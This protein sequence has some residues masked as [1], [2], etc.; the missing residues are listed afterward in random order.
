[1]PQTD[2]RTPPPL[3]LPRPRTRVAIVGATG[4]AGQELV[5]LLARH[6][7]R[8]P[9]AGDRI[10]GHAARR[11]GCRRSRASGTAR[12]C[13]ST[14][15]AVGAR[16]RH[17]LPGAARSRIGRAGAAAARRRRARRSISRARS[18]CATTP[19]APSGTRRPTALPAGVVYGLTEFAAAAIA[20]AL[21]GVVSGLLPDG[22]AAGAAAARRGRPA[23]PRRRRHRRRQVGDLGR[24]QGAVR[25]HALLREPRQRRRLRRCSAIAT[26]RR[27]RRRS[28]ATSPSRRIS[29]RSI[30]ACSRRSTRGSRP[31]RPRR[32]WHE[33]LDRRARGGRRSCGSP[34]TTL[35]EIKH[36][37]WTE[38]LRHRLEGGRGDGPHHPR[39]GP[40]QPGEGRRR[41]GRAELQPAARRRRA[42]RTAVSRIV[43]LKFGGELLEDPARD[44]GAGRVS[45]ARRRRA[46]PLVVVHGGGT[47]DRP[48]LA[49]AGIAKQQVD[50]LRVTDEATLD[51]VVAVLAG[52]LNTR[53][54]A[55]AQR[56]RRAG[57]RPD[58]RRRQRGAGRRGAALHRRR[59]RAP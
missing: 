36:V 35:P 59:R 7:A 6:P 55:D 54:V 33:A 10:A 20:G 45:S 29:C 2:T 34:A 14:S 4:Y 39:L 50:G 37:A 43:V 32:R 19:R 25:S 30:A 31:A 24:R 17:R 21:A 12:W 49:A 28:A 11:G 48:A 46:A 13:R 27:W 3:R 5:R 15:Q 44:Q 9:D 38:L 16:R 53:L 8:P 51:V 40:R 41:T 22:V 23:A 56:R 58:R 47:R 1:M 18:G 57:G 52:L 42:H 26:R